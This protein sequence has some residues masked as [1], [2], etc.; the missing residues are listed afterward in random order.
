MTTLK[1]V[2]IAFSLIAATPNFAQKKD[3][4]AKPTTINI[5]SSYK[6]VLR[7]ATK[8]NFVATQVPLDT[9]KPKLSYKVPAQ[10][11]FYSYQ[12]ISLQPLALQ[13]DNTINL[14][15]KGFV[16]IGYGNFSAPYVQ[17]AYSAGDGVTNLFNVYGLY[18]AAKGNIN[19]Q[20]YANLQLKANGILFLPTAE[21]RGGLEFT[22]NKTNA[23]GYNQALFTLPKDSVKRN[24]NN[25][26]F[27]IGVKN[28][29]K[30]NFDV[31][32][33]PSLN[34]NILT[35]TNRA[36]ETNILLQV[37][38]QKTI[39]ENFNV[40][41]VVN[42]D[43]T[44]YKNKNTATSN[45]IKNNIFQVGGGIN[46]N[47]QGVEVKAGV[48]PTWDNKSFFALPNI[49]IEAP[50]AKNNLIFQAGWV[51]SYQKNNLLNLT[52]V[53]PFINN[54]TNQNNTKQVELYGGLKA[55]VDNHF[56]FSAKVGLVS[57]TN[58]ALFLNDT[59][60]TTQRDFV[61]VTEPKMNNFRI[62]GNLH[63]VVRD[64]FSLIAGVTLNAYT[65]LSKHIKPWH[66]PP[67]ELNAS[68]KY[69]LKQNL[70]LKADLL[71]FTA[72]DF[73]SKGNIIGTTSTIFD[74]AAGLEFAITKKINL[75]LDVNNILNTKY[76]RW[77][78]YRVLGLQ[79]FG[80]A[81]FT[82]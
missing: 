29:V 2:L 74:V 46:F 30:N 58:K 15:S 50:L 25:I 60:S 38:I 42:A 47:Y 65:G 27:N 20:Q 26:G 72:S 61:V 51:G 35:S 69:K 32:Y 71:G 66:L 81:K 41:I 75:W 48:L 34:I 16:K 17:G 31:D 33:Q 78:G 10:N 40:D 7:S 12:P 21:V 54:L 67:I 77:N 6:P 8:I 56:S 39:S 37:P 62:H 53:N 11:L 44:S 52:N 57:Y 18:N 59:A 43:I 70:F 73:A 28:T 14:G 49:Y 24:Y 3:T 64:N 55:A 45:T 23:F 76:Q 63:Y 68:A 1:Y 4:T 80:G 19:Y 22:N 13:P 36:A 79:V 5:T 9:T 82:F